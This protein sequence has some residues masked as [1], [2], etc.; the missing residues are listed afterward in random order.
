MI[1]VKA[2]TDS[3]KTWELHPFIKVW[4]EKYRGGSKVLNFYGPAEYFLEDVL[5]WP[6]SSYEKLCIDIGGTNF[7]VGESVFVTMSDIREFLVSQGIV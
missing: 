1:K 6:L 4:R 3:G 2:F 5:K 7:G